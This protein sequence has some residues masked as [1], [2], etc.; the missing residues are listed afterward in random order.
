MT[1]R[2]YLENYERGFLLFLFS[3]TGDIR[4]VSKLELFYRNYQNVSNSSDFIDFFSVWIEITGDFFIELNRN[5]SK[6]TS[7]DLKY[8]KFHLRLTGYTFLN[9]KKSELLSFY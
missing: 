6:L 9:R 8:F 1:S 3:D 7:K 2:K 4:L 5:H